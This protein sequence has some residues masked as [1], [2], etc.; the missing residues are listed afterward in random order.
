MRT[1]IVRAAGLALVVVAVVAGSA[2][3]EF[4][5]RQGYVAD[6]AGVLD[7]STRQDILQQLLD[8]ERET[9][10]E[11]ALAIVGS[12]DG[13]TVED[14]ANRLF[15]AWGI[16]KKGAD[17]GVLVLIAPS[18]RK[19]RIEVGYGLEPILPDGLAGEVIRTEFTPR[20]KDGDYPAGIR[21]GMARIVE[22]VRR[23]H[24]L[25]AEE[26]KRIAEAESG[27]RPPALLM[28]PFFGTFVAVGAFMI[29]AGLGSKT[30]FPLLFG[31]LFGGIPFLMAMIPFFNASALSMGLIALVAGVIGFRKGGPAF[32]EQTA[33]G[34][35]RSRALSRIRGGRS[36]PD[37]GWTWGASSGG[38]SSGSSSSS[39]SSSS[40]S[41]GGG[42]S[43]GGG[44]S[45]SW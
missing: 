27:D 45:G 19:M 20:F 6:A 43:G 33:S 34:S 38:S 1:A 7:P 15:K 10:A 2:A 28:I 24:V 42:S 35:R 39:S 21:A 23:N 26:R 11:I 3:A 14:Y 29:G 31:G 40:G 30:F 9:R 41:F 37:S 17:N 13:M 18:E 36:T 4:P 8:V 44:A 12:L 22:I 32:A 25:S 5:P 16:G